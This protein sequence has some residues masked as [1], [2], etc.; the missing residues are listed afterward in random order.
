M[1]DGLAPASNL[2]EEKKVEQQEQK[3]EAEKPVAE[4]ELKQFTAEELADYAGQTG[5]TPIYISV[6]FT[7]YDVTTGRDFYGPGAGY[8]VFAGTD[9][10]RPLGKMQISDK[11]ANAGWKNLSEE[12]MKILA[13]WE[14]KYK[15]KY[16]VVGR[17]VPD[18][19]FEAR[20]DAFEP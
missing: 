4:G 19:G 8:H 7:V 13:D 18:E 2:Q 9:A 5:D 10:S 20:G 1:S 6:R 11:E 3:L 16:P 15:V 14:D 17:F 12:H